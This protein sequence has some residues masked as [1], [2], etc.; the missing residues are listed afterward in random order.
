MMLVSGER[1]SC[2]IACSTA[3]FNNLRS[4]SRFR[5]RGLR[6][7]PLALE[8]YVDEPRKCLPMRF[9]SSSVQLSSL[10]K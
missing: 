4:P 7:Q 9:W 2:E 10:L 5:F 8:R 3:V 6:I 1:R